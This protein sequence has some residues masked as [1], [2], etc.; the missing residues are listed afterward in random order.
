M[1]T[2]GM[3]YLTK[4]EKTVLSILKEPQRY[5]KSDLSIKIGKSVTT[6]NRIIKS[7][8]ERDLIERVGSNK[9]GYWVVK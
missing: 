8:T 3:A 2:D 9:T 7:L 6:V 5:T 4:D 1:I